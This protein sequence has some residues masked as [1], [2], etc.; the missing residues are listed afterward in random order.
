MWEVDVT[1]HEFRLKHAMEVQAKM[2]PY[3]IVRTQ[4][5]GEKAMYGKRGTGRKQPSSFCA[6]TRNKKNVKP[7]K[8]VMVRDWNSDVVVPE[9]PGPQG[10]TP[11]EQHA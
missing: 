10:R 5:P 3:E 9:A 1:C 11:G 8:Q 2:H 6:K 7:R 4:P